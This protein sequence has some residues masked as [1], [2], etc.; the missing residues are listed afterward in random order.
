MQDDIGSLGSDMAVNNYQ[1][2][3]LQPAEVLLS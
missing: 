3:Q 1:N 2:V